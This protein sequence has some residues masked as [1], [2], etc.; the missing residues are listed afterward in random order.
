MTDP[1]ETPAEQTRVPAQPERPARARRRQPW[2][3]D[4]ERM[5]AEIRVRRSEIARQVIA[6]R[7]Q[8]RRERPARLAAPGWTADAQRAFIEHLAA[9]G[10][11]SH[12]A[13]AVGLSKQSAYQLR[14]RSPNSLFALAWNVAIQRS[15]RILLDQATERAMNG[16][17][18]P[19]FHRGQE[20]GTQIVHNDRLLMFLLAMK[21]DPVHPN[22]SEHELAELWP[23]MLA[24]IDVI[25]PNTLTAD[26]LEDR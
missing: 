20:V 8:R 1:V 9:H 15:R 26:R 3:V 7:A 2:E 25:M 12:A 19:I 10:C 11:V 4:Q 16:Q 14:D 13:H 22:L 17:E 6:A 24:Q 5:E 21:R 23:T 18:K